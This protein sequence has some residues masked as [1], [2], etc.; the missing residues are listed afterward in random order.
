MPKEKRIKIDFLHFKGFSVDFYRNKYDFLNPEYKVDFLCYGEHWHSIQEAFDSLSTPT[1]S[2]KEKVNL[3][4]N[5]LYYRFQTVDKDRLLD[6]KGQWICQTVYNC[7]NFWHDCACGDCFMESGNNYYG[8]LLMEV[9]DRFIWE[10]KPNAV[11]K[12]RWKVRYF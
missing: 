12:K 1:M 3:M 2:T 7:D 5:L 10:N 9:R 8:R 6:T 4:G 11:N